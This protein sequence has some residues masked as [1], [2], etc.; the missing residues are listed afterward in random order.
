MSEKSQIQ[1]CREKSLKYQ[2]DHV[3]AV[4]YNHLLT[5]M[6]LIYDFL[7]YYGHSIRFL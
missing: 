2:T 6:C 4:N 1:K 3:N 7:L 5:L